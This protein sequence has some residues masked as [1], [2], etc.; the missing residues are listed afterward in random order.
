MTMPKLWKR[1]FAGRRNEADESAKALQGGIELITPSLIAGW[2]YHPDCLL[3][4]VRLLAGPHLLAQ[5]RIDH[6]RADV[7]DHL[8]LKGQ[9]GFELEIPPD[10]PLLRIEAAPIVLALS[11]DGSRRFPLSLIGARSSTQARLTTALQPDMRGLRGHFDGLSPDG[12][13]VHGWCY[14]VGGREPAQVWLQAKDLPPRPLICAERRPGMANQGHQDTCGFSLA[15]ADWPEAAGATLWVTYD[16]EG[17][18]RL[19]QAAP[20]HVPP[21][22]PGPEATVLVRDGQEEIIPQ[23]DLEEPV[24]HRGANRE[25]WQALESFQRYLDGLERELDRH[26]GI[27]L[28]PQRQKGIWAR[29]LGSDR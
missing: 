29:L 21:R 10:L 4:D 11:A 17:V 22:A 8:Q 9:F 23:P 7:E 1:L 12:T 6:H 18:L 27:Q 28:R 5:A 3:S 2:A 25:H 16:P 24:L 13:R 15:L 26:E 19:P 20:V 14:K